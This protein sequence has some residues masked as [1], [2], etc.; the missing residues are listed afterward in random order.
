MS[1]KTRRPLTTDQAMELS[2]N[3]CPKCQFEE[4]EGV[5]CSTR[6]PTCLRRV[7]FTGDYESGL[8]Y[9]CPHCGKPGEM[10]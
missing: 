4:I 5:T 2:F 1:K 10:K 9:D 3:P 7:W 8:K 6:C